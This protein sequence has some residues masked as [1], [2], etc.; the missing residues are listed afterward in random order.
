MSVLFEKTEFKGVEL[1]N[2]LVRSATH[3]GMADEN[4]FPTDNL[5]KFYERIAQGGVGLIITGF[6][7][8]SR[9]GKSHAMMG[10]DRD[11]HISKYRELVGHVH[12]NGAKIAMQINHCG[13]QTTKEMTGTQ[14]IAPSAVK[15]NMLLDKPR[16]M[17]EEDIEKVIK[18]FGL[19]SKRVR[20]S[21]FDAV[22]LHGAHGYLINQFLCPHT[23]RRKDKWGGPIENRM[24]IVKRIYSAC[25][26]KVG[27]DYPILIKISAY[28]NMKNGLKLEEGIIMAEMMAD[29]GF[30]GI[31]VSCG[32]GEDGG[33]TVRGDIPIDVILEELPG[34]KKSN[35]VF[36]FVLRHF[37]KKI[38]KPVPFSQ[39]FNREAA[40]IIKSKVSIPIFLVGGMTDPSAMEDVIAKGDADY[41]SLS[42]ALINNPKFP[43]NIREG[44]REPSKCLHCNLCLFRVVMEPLRCYYGKK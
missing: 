26:E 33:S 16:A 17:T 19:A 43:S 44:S 32:V 9:D 10:I 13:R 42:R 34:Y 41:I 15:D 11:E 6:S 29:M 30:D 25:R 5:F 2:R 8:V 27:E 21:N 36:K 28:D 12:K 20:A 39:S 23:N 18:N 35:P 1:K 40:K 4:G 31:E 37:G 3:E 14:T 22:Q 24:R 38:V 7:Y